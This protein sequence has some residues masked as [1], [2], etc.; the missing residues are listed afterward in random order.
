MAYQGFA[1]S[2]FDGD[3]YCLRAWLKTGE[4]CFL[5]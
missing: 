5:G 3:A 2:D 4:N 1:T